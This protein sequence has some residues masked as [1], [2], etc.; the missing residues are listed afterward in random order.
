MLESSSTEKCLVV[1]FLRLAGCWFS[2]VLALATMFMWLGT[3]YLYQ[4]KSLLREL[5]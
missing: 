3:E 4:L 2:T 1:R 5:S